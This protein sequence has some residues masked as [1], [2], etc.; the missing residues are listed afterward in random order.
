GSA[1]TCPKA[2]QLLRRSCRRRINRRYTSPRS[3]FRFRSHTRAAD[4]SLELLHQVLHDEA[5]LRTDIDPYLATPK[6]V[7]DHRPH[8][9]HFSP[10]KPLL[11]RSHRAAFASDFEEPLDLWRTRENN[12]VDFAVRQLPDKIG[13]L[14]A[15]GTG[16]VKIGHHCPNCRAGRSQ[17]VLQARVRL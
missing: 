13:N 4:L 9:S 5:L 14:I 15:I 10:L 12:R 2:R 17:E 16:G 6:I 11:E 7:R 1:R 8:G 3:L